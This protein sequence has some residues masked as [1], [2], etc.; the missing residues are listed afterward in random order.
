MRVDESER[1]DIA[2]IS[3]PVN[4][5]SRQ[6][7]KLCPAVDNLTHSS[8]FIDATHRV[9]WDCKGKTGAGITLHKGAVISLSWKQKG[10]KEFDQD[11][12]SQSG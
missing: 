1:I 5:I 10:N 2:Y 9:H 4:L 7:L 6:T 3:I 11:R 8:W 12:A